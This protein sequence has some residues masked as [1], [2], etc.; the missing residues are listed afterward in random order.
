MRTCRVRPMVGT[1][2]SSTGSQW[3]LKYELQVYNS[4]FMEKKSHLPTVISLD[5]SSP[6]REEN[7]LAFN[8]CQ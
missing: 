1:Q 8:R 3:E 6:G 5:T 2:F 4:T 7:S